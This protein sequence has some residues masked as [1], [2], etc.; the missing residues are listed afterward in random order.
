MTLRMPSWIDLAAIA[1][2][3]VAFTLVTAKNVESK[4]EATLLNV[5]YDPTRELYR[6]LDATFRARY[7]KDTGQRVQIRQSH[8]G[9][10]HQA[11]LAANGELAPDVVTL[12]LPS[13]VD[14]LRKRGLIPYGWEVRL[15]NRSRPYYST[16]IFVVRRGNPR[17]I[18]DWPDLVKP[19]IEVITPDPKSSGNGKLAALAAWGAITTRGGSEDE[20][21]TFLR[22]L[23]DHAPFL[24][25]AA[26]SAGSAFAIERIGD[27]HLAWENEALREVGEAHGELE[28]VYPPV[29]ILAEPAVAWVDANVETD[30]NAVAARAYLEYLFTDEAQEIIARNG[31]RPFNPQVLERHR[32]QLPALE[33]FPV[34]AVAHNWDD[35]QNR[36]FADNGIIDAVYRP[37]PR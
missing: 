16:I 26:R 3:V 14:V 32:A 12:G 2:I 23:Y 8:G 11:R 18:H 29:S 31:Y 9:S 19:G 15:P 20:A 28:L 6:D 33:L 22:V 37:K 34:T 17:A 36:F 24:V 10:S 1:G 5:S 35:A 4:A 25:A 30:G 21:R 13:D 7:E 27:V